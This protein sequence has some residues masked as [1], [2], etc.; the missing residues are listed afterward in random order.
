MH[1]AG[2]LKDIVGPGHYL[3][4]DQIGPKYSQD[5]WGGDREGDPHLVVCPGSTEEVAAVL[6]A[7]HEAGQPV[8]PQGGMTGLVSAGVPTRDEVVLSLERLNRIED[9][10]L[11]TN[12]ATVQAGVTLQELQDRVEQDGLIF[13]LDLASRGSCTLGGSLSTNAGGN[14]VLLYGMTRDLTLGVEAVL[15]DGTVVNGLHKLVK[16]NAGYDLKHLFIGTEGTLG[17]VTRAVLRLRPKPVTQLA[18][19]CGLR[20]VEDAVELLNRLRATLPGMVSAFEAIWASAYRV[21]V[22]LRDTVRLPLEDRH[23]I[24]ALVECVGSDPDHDASRFL[25]AMEACKDV[26]EDAAVGQTEQ[27]VRQIW[28][29]R[30]R[31]PGEVLRMQPLFGFDISLAPQEMAGY[32][33]DVDAELRR[34]WP[35]VELIVFGHLGDG[36]IHIAV[37]TG[38]KTKERKPFIEEIVYRHVGLR[39]GSISAEHGIGFEKRPYLHFSRSPEEIDLM[40]RLKSALDPRGVL[41]PGRIFPLTPSS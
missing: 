40:R 12:T 9:V 3:E 6:R 10:D 17:V 35:A 34:T 27:E 19:F 18:A 8:V 24:Y 14:R 22:P 36:N 2:K 4:G 39:G 38:E 29:V 16:N 13:P 25:A 41:S 15:A 20:S 21:V 37:V 30:E 5:F 33:V 7:C 23:N 26:I 32:L 11:I 31:I 28:Q 1:V